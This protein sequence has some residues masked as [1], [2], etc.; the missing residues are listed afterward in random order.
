MT[1]MRRFLQHYDKI[2]LALGVVV[3]L[4]AGALGATRLR[5][6]DEIAA[7]NPVAGIEPARYELTRAVVPSIAMVVWNEAPRQSTGSEWVYDVFTPPVIYYNPQTQQ[8][9]VTPPAVTGPVAVAGNDEPYDIELIGV[10]QE[11]YRI[12]LVGYV[13]TADNPIATFEIVDS[14]ETVVGRPGRRFE[15][16]EFTLQS[17]EITRLTTPAGEGMPVVENVARA[18]VL[19]ERSGREEVLTNRERKMMPRLQATFRVNVYPGETRTV[20]EGSSIEA[21]GQVYQVT[22]IS[23]FP[24][25]AV[26]S[27]R[28]RDALG[29]NETRT[30]SPSSAGGPQSSPTRG[31]GIVPAPE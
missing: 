31:S 23:M 15:R 18:V 27:R 6:L 16:Q 13:G 20:Y 25:Q 11:P 10:R 2:L 5:K 8:F 12:Q 24:P 4:A 22:Q 19:D 29:A 26:V 30:L 17:F 9:T 21:N 7:R 28:S 1:A 3:F 14:G